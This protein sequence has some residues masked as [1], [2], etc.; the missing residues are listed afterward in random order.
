VSTVV[1]I[2]DRDSWEAQTDN[3]VLVDAK[4]R[5]LLWIPRDL[6]SEA[7]GD[8]VN[9]AFAR[10]GHRLLMEALGEYG[11]PVG[12]SMCFRRSALE[13]ALEGV[14]ISVPVRRQLKLWYPLRPTERLEDGRKVV[15]FEPPRECLAGERIHQWLGARSAVGPVAGAL[16]DLER[17]KRQK[18]FVRRLLEEQTQFSKLLDDP[19]LVSLAGRDEALADLARVQPNW[20]FRTLDAVRPAAVDGK[21]VLAAAR[22]GGVRHLG[23][24]V[25][26]V[27]G[28]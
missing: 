10:G 21:L 1:S 14:C 18:V 17:I 22:T 7:V 23:R 25:R 5:R 28:A 4:R 9:A 8:R 24:L 19:A 13:Q 6:W 11:L 16:P 15:T 12:A 3:I 26:H 20:R 2:M 27:V